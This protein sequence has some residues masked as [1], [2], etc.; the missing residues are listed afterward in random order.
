MVSSGTGNA[1]AIQEALVAQN[2]RGHTGAVEALRM[3]ALGALEL[4]ELIELT[5][6]L[7][8]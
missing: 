8:E 7:H 1:Q 4:N 6:E 5:L 2:H 3:A